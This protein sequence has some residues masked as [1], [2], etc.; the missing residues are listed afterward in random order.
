MSPF[1]TCLKKPAWESDCEREKSQNKSRWFAIIRGAK[2]YF[3]L[4]GY[5]FKL[6]VCRLTMNIDTKINLKWEYTIN[7]QLTTIFN[8][9]FDT[10]I[11]KKFRSKLFCNWR[12]WCSIIDECVSATGSWWMKMIANL[13][14]DERSFLKILIKQQ[15]QEWH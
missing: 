4:D 6:C 13:A 2:S 1:K 12:S 9:F 3:H 7:E 11:I 8:H 5:L 14:S 10:L 15:Q